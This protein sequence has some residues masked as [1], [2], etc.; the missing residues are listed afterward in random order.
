MS[1]SVVKLNLKSWLIFFKAMLPKLWLF[2]SFSGSALKL[3][4]VFYCMFCG[5]CCWNNYWPEYSFGLE[6][7]SFYCS[8]CTI[9]GWEKDTVD[10]FCLG[11]YQFWNICE[12]LSARV[13]FLFCNLS[14]HEVTEVRIFRAELNNECLVLSDLI[15]TRL[16]ILAILPLNIFEYFFGVVSLNLFLKLRIVRLTSL[17]LFDLLTRCRTGLNAN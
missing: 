17:P 14:S 16:F 8:G 1:W 2:L 4:V 3:C 7:C 5:T 6:F 10:F 12:L 15:E 13:E 9:S 11:T